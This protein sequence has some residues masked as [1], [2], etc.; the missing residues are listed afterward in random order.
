MIVD[1][2]IQTFK[3]FMTLLIATYM[4]NLENIPHVPINPIYLIFI[5]CKIRYL[6]LN[7]VYCSIQFL[8]VL[9][10]LFPG[11]FCNF[12]KDTSYSRSIVLF[13]QPLFAFLIDLELCL[14]C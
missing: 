10:Y 3:T 12:E 7:V 8:Y 14:E 6:C 5:E 4:I 9:I 11:S 13:Y 2:E 1:S